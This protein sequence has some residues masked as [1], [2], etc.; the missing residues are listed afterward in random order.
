MPQLLFT[1]SPLF[2]GSSFPYL[3]FISLLLTVICLWLQP[4]QLRQAFLGIR[5]THYTDNL[6]KALGSTHQE[7]KRNAHT[8]NI[9][10]IYSLTQ[11]ESPVDV[12]TL[13]SPELN[14]LKVKV[15][16]LI[17]TTVFFS[18]LS[19]TSIVSRCL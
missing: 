3:P 12:L 11:C 7:K 2:L 19:L 4:L 9:L 6:L 10:T 17:T 16:N 1:V 15:M 8:R 14:T 18:V 13:T 5:V